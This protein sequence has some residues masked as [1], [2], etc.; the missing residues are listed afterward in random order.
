MRNHKSKKAT[1]LSLAG[2]LFL[3]VLKIIVGLMSGSLAL[4][5]EAI[6]SFLDVLTSIAAYISVKV[7]AKI[8]DADHPF[9]HSRAEPI[10][11]LIVAIV[12]VMLGL[13][14][15]NYAIQKIISGEI[16]SL[17]LLPLIALLI[18]IVVKLAMIFYFKDVVKDTRSPA[19]KACEID[20]RNDVLLAIAAIVGVIGNMLGY[21][22]LDPIAA[23][24]LGALV[25]K[26]GYDIGKENINFLV[27]GRPP[28]KV[29][30]QIEKKALG[31]TGVID[32]HDIRAHYVGNNAHV[33]VHVEI[34]EK[35]DLKK[36]HDIGEEAKYQIE[37]IDVVEE[38]FIHIDPVKKRKKH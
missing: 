20:S 18:T 5:S 1:Q 19:V 36:A 35:L 33:E 38:A 27:G 21:K 23:I 16:V 10:A 6:N 11:G 12:A 26:E 7:S 28:K 30:R 14:V 8:A 32:V 22:F 4:I 29:L 15:I 34:D 17:G 25:I 24:V 37:D 3:F 2:N 31:V 13:S 9:G